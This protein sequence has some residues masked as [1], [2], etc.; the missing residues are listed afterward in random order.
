MSL[1]EKFLNKKILKTTLLWT[2]RSIWGTKEN[3]YF[4][5]QVSVPNQNSLCV[6]Y[7]SNVHRSLVLK[8]KKKNYLHI[9]NDKKSL[10]YGF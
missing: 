2:S 9:F 5:L 10:Y 8:I 7:A 6:P 4:G 3:C 1:K